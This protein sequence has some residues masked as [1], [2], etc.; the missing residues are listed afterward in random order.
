MIDIARTLEAGLWFFCHAFN[1]NILQ[2]KEKYSFH[3]EDL[4]DRL[5]DLSEYAAHVGLKS[6]GLEQMYT[7][8]QVPWTIKGAHDLLGN[9][10]GRSRNPFLIP[11][12]RLIKECLQNVLK[13]ISS[14]KSLPGLPRYLMISLKS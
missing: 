11:T 7:P 12:G 4:Y 10:Y 14:L 13:S 6:L 8:H 1:N 9:V 2:D 3:I 5:A